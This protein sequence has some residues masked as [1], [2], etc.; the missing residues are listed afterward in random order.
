MKVFIG[1]LIGA[2]AVFAWS[3]V[4]WEVLHLH[5]TTIG[6]LSLAQEQAAVAALQTSLPEEGAYFLPSMQARDAD[7]ATTDAWKARHKQGPL[8]FI[9]YKKAGTDPEDPTTYAVGFAINL[10][11]AFLICLILSMS[12]MHSFFTRF[13]AVGLIGLFAGGVSHLSQVNWMH[14]PLDFSVL[15]AADTFIG[16][17]IGGLF[18]AMIVRPRS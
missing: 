11:G 15:M 7:Q 14:F 12:G 4:S 13:G 1:A 6:K 18:M 3:F 16:W 8:G 17:T 2:I 10:A 9:A 5:D